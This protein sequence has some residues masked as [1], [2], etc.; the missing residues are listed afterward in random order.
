M[1][2]KV[3]CKLICTCLTIWLCCAGNQTLGQDT[4][5]FSSLGDKI[6]LFDLKNIKYIQTNDAVTYPEITA[7]KFNGE[8]SDGSYKNGHAHWIKATLFNDTDNNTCLFFYTAN[9]QFANLYA[10]NAQ[11]SLAYTAA[12]GI[13]M[14]THYLESKNSIDYVS[15]PITKGE[16]LNVYIRLYNIT[17]RDIWTNLRLEK[18]EYYYQTL[19]LKRK[20]ELNETYIIII[21]CSALTFLLLFMAFTYL[22]NKQRNY[23]YFCIYLLGAVVYSCT[24]LNSSTLLGYWINHVPFFR[25]LLNE[26]SQFLFFA[27]YNLFGIELLNIKKNDKLLYKILRLLSLIY[28]SYAVFHFS[29]IAI[30][31]NVVMRD[32]LFF[33]SRIVLFPINA[34]IILRTYFTLRKLLIYKYF[35]IGVLIY[36]FS[37]II[38]AF[39]DY[40]FRTSGTYGSTLTSANIFQL[41]IMAETLC[42]AFAIGYKT[43]L[44]DDER[45]ENQEN[46]IAQLKIN[47]VLAEKTNQELEEKIQ[48]RTDE[49]VAYQN[50]IQEQ[51]KAELQ[52]IYEKKISDIEN[53]ALRSQMNPHF[54]F[55]SLNAIKFFIL[56]N[57]NKQATNYLNRFSKLIRLILEHSKESVISLTDE[58]TALK[59]Y[60]E[61]ESTR[62]DDTFSYTINIQNDVSVD[63][64]FVPPLLL[65]PFVENA[66][67]H[68]LLPKKN[69]EKLLNISILVEVTHFVFV[70]EDNGI[71]RELSKQKKEKDSRSHRSLGMKITEERIDLFNKNS[72]RNIDLT[73]IDLPN[74][75]G[76]RVE[77]RYEQ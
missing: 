58:L 3:V 42:F 30:T 65:Q 61:I 66:I 74:H 23:L 12:C 76:T 21:F 17:N 19:Q 62:F 55:N 29:Y 20:S 4:L 24:R 47:Q 60:L 34:L 77:I 36:F 26:P 46:Y 1:H 38:A 33:I 11:S 45:K 27:A 71:G 35:I 68:G 43:K 28:I 37:A 48:E 10:Q 2:Y 9:V 59:L 32:K 15:L 52:L 54:L 75:S 49:V 16:T 6:N 25:T 7:F 53:V 64:L 44:I 56:S 31:H 13:Y 70:I 8:L 72:K 51:K 50:Q 5:R 18:S 40:L 73:I 22:K 69:G 57:Q 39:S 67:W 14:P 63:Q 41:G